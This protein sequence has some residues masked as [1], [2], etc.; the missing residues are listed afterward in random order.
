MSKGIGTT[1]GILAIGGG[2]IGLV[3]AAMQM[4]RGPQPFA[5]AVTLVFAMAYLFGIWCGVAILQRRPGWLRLNRIFWGAQLLTIAT[6]IVSYS[7]SSGAVFMVWVRSS[8]WGNGFYTWIGSSFDL[9]VGRDGHVLFGLNLL[10]L[11]ITV[12][13]AQKA[14]RGI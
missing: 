11:A 12:Y 10:A 7:F 3:V 1:L 6:P 13:L 8:P 4:G 2:V 14:A 5:A 9:A